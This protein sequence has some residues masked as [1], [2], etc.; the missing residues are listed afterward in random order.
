MVFLGDGK[1]RFNYIPQRESGLKI[2]GNVR[3]ME[4]LTTDNSKSLVFGLNDSALK[5]VRLK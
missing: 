2:R 1:G 5:L 4:V 3:S